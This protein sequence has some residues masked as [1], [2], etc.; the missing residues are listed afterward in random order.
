MTMTTVRNKMKAAD[1]QIH[2]FIGQLFN[3]YAELGDGHFSIAVGS[4]LHDELKAELRNRPLWVA[5]YVL[6]SFKRW[7]QEQRAI[8]RPESELTFGNCARETGMLRQGARV[9]DDLAQCKMDD[10]D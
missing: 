9:P 1:K 4:P 7:T 2:A 8:G 3:K 6:K 10:P 5:T